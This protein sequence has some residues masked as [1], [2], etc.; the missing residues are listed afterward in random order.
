[1][2]LLVYANSFLANPEEK[3]APGTEVVRAARWRRSLYTEAVQAGYTVAA[4]AAAAAVA[5]ASA[6]AATP[7]LLE[8][9]GFHAALLDVT[10]PQASCGPYHPRTSLDLPL[11]LAATPPPTGARVDGELGAA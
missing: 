4:K 8:S 9:V 1:M 5:G 6:T 3:A 10:H 7:H 11:M 2:R